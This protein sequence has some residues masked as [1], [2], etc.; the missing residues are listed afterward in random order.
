MGWGDAKLQLVGVEKLME[1]L[2]ELNFA[3]QILG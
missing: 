1:W 2:L 3:G